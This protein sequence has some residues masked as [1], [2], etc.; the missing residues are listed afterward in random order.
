MVLFLSKNI[1]HFR[2]HV[3]SLPLIISTLRTDYWILPSPVHKMFVVLTSG[4]EE[5]QPWSTD[6]RLGISY[7]SPAYV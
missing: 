1:S 5:G 6:L 2:N 3:M 7:I 4:S